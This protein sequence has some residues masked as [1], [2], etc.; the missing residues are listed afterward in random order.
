MLRVCFYV[1]KKKIAMAKHISILIISV[2]VLLVDLSSARLNVKVAKDVVE[3]ICAKTEDPSY[4]S[5]AIESDPRTGAA[6][7]TGL[8]EICIDLA[9]DGAKK[10]EALV[11]GL[12][13]NASDPQLKDKYTACSQ[14]F[15]AAIEDLGEASEDLRAGNSSGVAESG[16]DGL[17]E[18]QNC[19]DEFEA[20]PKDPSDLLGLVGKLITLCGA[21]FFA[22]QRI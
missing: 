6:N 5:H 20:P 15:V 2:V 10:A 3:K 17:F 16:L 4:C 1:K 8:A 14:N 22:G 13:K 18:A 7:L 12:I 19:R 21:V 9:G 11:A